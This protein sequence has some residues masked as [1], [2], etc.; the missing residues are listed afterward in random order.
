MS[1]FFKDCG[2]LI[3]VI[4]YLEKLATRKITDTE[5]IVRRII[6][7]SKATIQS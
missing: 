5:M 3:E 7:I 1:R 6:A 2:S 4:N